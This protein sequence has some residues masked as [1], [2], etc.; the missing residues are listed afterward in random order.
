MAITISGENNNDKILA[1]DG[2]ID[3]ISGINIVGLITASH[4]NVGSNI[5]LG[6]AGIITATTFV[7][8]VTGNVNSTSP[9][10]LQTGGSERFRIT[11]NNELGIAGANYGSSGQVL[12][13]GGSGS[14]VSW[15]TPAITGFTN[16]SDNRIVTCTSASAITGESNLTFDGTKLNI[17]TGGAGFRITRNSQYIELDGNFGN[18][19]DQTLA[20]SAAFRIQTGGVG[21]SYE[22][23]RITSDGQI[24]INKTSPKA[25]NTSYTSLQIQDAGYIV[26]STDDSFVAIGANNYLDTGGTYD[27][28]NSDFASQLY[29]V[30][31]ELV[32]R[33]AASGTAD[34]AITWSEKLRITSAGKVGINV[35]TPGSHL[36]IRN[37]GQVDVCIGSTNAGGAM[38]ILDGDSNGDAVGADYSYIAHNTGG[39]LV[40]GADNPA[41]NADIVFKV[42]DN[43]EK[44]RIDSN[45]NLQVSTGQFTVGTTATSGLQFINDGTFGT[46]NSIP[47]II[48][49][50]SAERMQITST[51]QIL[52]GTGAIAT[53]K[54]SVGGLDVASGLYSIVMGGEANTGD[55]T[56]RANS[57]S[58][59][60]RLCVPHYTN[61]EEPLGTVVSF[62]QSGA[63]YLRFGGGSS[64]VNAATEIGFY[65]AANTT[66]TGGTERLKISSGGYVTKPNHPCFAA[67]GITSHTAGSGTHIDYTTQLFDNGG[68]NYDP[69]AGQSK[70]TAPVSGYYFFHATCMFDSNF[71]GFNYCFLDFKIS[72]TSQGRERMLPRPS[73]GQH[74]SIENSAIFYLTANQYVQVYITQSGGNPMNVR[75]DYRFFEGYLIG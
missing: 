1:T 32:F 38:L 55:G 51:G 21:N 36:D 52:I 34:N 73:G 66:T 54:A 59:E 45:G 37:T 62:T 70:F 43:T 23:L 40:I 11:G 74:V 48:R 49:T 60:A 35:D 47:L 9:L 33:S 3:Q 39:D 64:I 67:K 20:T 69:T 12:T 75:N 7:G 14:A 68:D 30:N 61:A 27:Y 46:L 28:T 15:A 44:V 17:T 56:P 24:G 71:T 16:G 26:G 2:V 41:G 8:N 63:S 25:W 58:K 31:G 50:A 5:Q 4:I 18:G 10:L 53:P 42:G 72:G 57:A 13:S 29:Q 6:N 22:R 65:T 19:G